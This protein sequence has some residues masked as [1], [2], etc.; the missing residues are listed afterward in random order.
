MIKKGQV[1]KLDNK[2]YVRLYAA[3]ESFDASESKYIARIGVEKLQDSVIRVKLQAFTF[4]CPTTDPT[5]KCSE[6]GRTIEREVDLSERERAIVVFERESENKR[7]CGSFQIDVR[8][9]EIVI[10]EGGQEVVRKDVYPGKTDLNRFVWAVCNRKK[11]NGTEPQNCGLPSDWQANCTQ[12]TP[13]PTATPTPVPTKA[14]TPTP[15]LTPT[16][17]PTKSP[18]TPTPTPTSTPTNTPTPTPIVVSKTTSTPTPTPT[19]TKGLI[20]AGGEGAGLFL[21][22]GVGTIL[23]SLMF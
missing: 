3:G 6:N 17:T 5:G 12:P 4:Y 10:K 14:S 18:N 19:K 8:V 15:T 23:V 13:T 11:V 7:H 2:E 21:L 16:P 20:K 1:Y 9:K 22:I